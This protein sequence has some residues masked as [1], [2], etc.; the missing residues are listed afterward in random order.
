MNENI[1]DKIKKALAVL[2]NSPGVYIMRDI[3]GKIIYVG[4]AIVLKNRVKSYFRNSDK[5]A[6]KVK[7]LV[8]KVDDLE[9]IVT[10]NEMEALILECNLIKENRPRY[11]ISLKDDKTYPFLKVTI[12]EDFPRIYSTRRMIKDGAK[13]YGPYADATAL[14]NTIRLIKSMFPLRT[15][16]KMNTDRPCLQYH[17]KRCLA[18]CVGKVSKESYRKMI[19]AVLLLLDG[20]TKKLEKNLKTKMKEAAEEYNYEEAARYRDSLRGLEK[21]QEE[22]KA[23]TEGG[24]Q[25]A[26]AIAK[27]ITGSCAQIFFIRNGKLV[28]R[29]SFF[30]ETENNDGDEKAILGAFVKQYYNTTSFIPKE[31]LLANE[32]PEEENEVIAN[33][34]AKKAEHKVDFLVPKRGLKHDLIKMVKEN[35]LKILNERLRK[36]QIALKSDEQAAEELQHALGLLEPLARMDCF[37]ISHTQGTETVASMVVFRYGKASKKDYRKYKIISAEGK[38]DDFK[39]MQEVVY[40]RYKDME[41]LP[42][43]VVIDGGKG[44]LSSS[45][46][47]IRGLGLHELNVIGLA[48]REEEIFTEGESES[49]L[50]KKDSAALHLIQRIRD[51]A[52]RFAITYHRK[53]RSKRNMVSVLDHIEGV[54][55][56]RRNAIWKKFEN[57]E[58]IKNASVEELASVDG[59]NYPVAQRIYDFFRMDIVDKQETLNKIIDRAEVVNK[60][61]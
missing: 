40:R 24:D 49:I 53:L 36:G 38:P 48:K 11:N 9:T 12:Q 35:A 25:D 14:Y 3:T 2:P 43:L 26:I 6:P 31:I 56:K 55:A 47:V 29:D 45:L 41:D 60:E 16:R 51:E 54:G 32:L 61:K 30:L 20:K 23:M 34:I 59:M 5:L 50:L 27:D 57:I 15:C 19:D 13:Y 21:L 42:N 22:Q 18:P 10:S 17:I 52:H 33:W 39:S 46:E 1:N 4:K 7:A 58:A 28:G 8:A 44:Q 37:D